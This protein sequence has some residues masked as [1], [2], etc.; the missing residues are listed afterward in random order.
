MDTI[1]VF[2]Q[3]H[4]RSELIEVLLGSTASV[5]E[6][7]EVLA[8]AA[9]EVDKD[10][11]IFIGDSDEP[12]SKELAEILRDLKDGTRIHVTRC[13]HVAATVN[14]LEHSEEHRFPPGTRVRAVKEWAVRKFK[15]DPKDAA[16]HVLQLCNS[17]SRPSSD[18]TLQELTDNHTCSVCFD[19]VPEKR[20]EG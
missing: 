20:V 4:G 12:L 15:I 6:L 17:T 9:I 11:H 10:T 18:T 19:L 16:E 3:A 5:S 2:L 7:L 1:T 13:R 8:A 14:Y